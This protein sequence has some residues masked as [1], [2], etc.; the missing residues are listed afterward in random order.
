MSPGYQNYDDFSQDS[1]YGQTSE[2][3]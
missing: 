2:V 3:E 1:Q